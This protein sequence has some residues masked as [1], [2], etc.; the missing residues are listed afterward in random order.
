MNYDDLKDPG[1]FS[2]IAVFLHIKSLK[3]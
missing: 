1:D 2:N 3:V